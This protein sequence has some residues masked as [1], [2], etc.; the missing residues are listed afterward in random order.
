MAL[1]GIAPTFDPVCER[2]KRASRSTLDSIRIRAIVRLRRG[3]RRFQKRD[4]GRGN[5][6]LT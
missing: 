5:C 6:S 3:Q 2:V 4:C 1:P